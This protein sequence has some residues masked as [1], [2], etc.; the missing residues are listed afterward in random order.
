[1]L[2]DFHRVAAALKD[3]KS[4]VIVAHERPDGDATGSALGLARALRGC[5]KKIALTGFMPAPRLY[6]FLFQR[7][8]LVKPAPDLLR[9][10]E[11]LIALD[12]GAVSR[13][14]AFG[15]EDLTALTVVNIDHHPTNDRYG[16]VAWIG[17][18]VSSTGEMIHRLLPLLGVEL[19]AAI[20]E[21]L[22]VAL[23]SDTGNF[24]YANTTP[25]T[26][27]AAAALLA[28][29]VDCNKIHRELHEKRQLNEVFLMRRALEKLEIL[30]DG[31]L[32][33]IALAQ[34][35]FDEFSADI[36]ALPEAVSLA[37]SIDGVQIGAYLREIAKENKIKVS[38]RGYEPF[39]MAKF[40]QQFGGGGHARAAGFHFTG[41]GLADAK[42]RVV[43][44]L[45]KWLRQGE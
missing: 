32:G 12:C 1:M 10:H 20:A 43:A 3:L 28:A 11:A 37:H 22:W 19:T 38:L 18:N 21:P 25:E 27:R 30:A 42:G 39:D 2:D 5:G 14:A 13:L 26:L 44:A 23:I 9:Q 33:L 15:G 36:N 17:E 4:A 6:D 34:R 41:I 24:S 8:E 40:S 7:G 29:G 35:D 45:S 16:N 31:K